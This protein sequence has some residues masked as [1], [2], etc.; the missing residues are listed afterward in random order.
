MRTP[1]PILER[2][3]SVR[4]IQALP[5]KIGH[6]DYEIEAETV[7]ISASGAMCRI[8]RD[9][10]LMTQLRIGLCLPDGQGRKRRIEIK[11]VTVRKELDALSGK[12]MVAIFFSDMKSTDQQTLK[13]YIDRRLSS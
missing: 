11:G 3:R 7:N 8:N 9:I 6:K 2:R 12:F 10:P 13:E 5:F 1:K 4:L